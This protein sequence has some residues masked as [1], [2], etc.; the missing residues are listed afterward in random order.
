MFVALDGNF[1]LRRR[2]ASKL[3]IIKA[4]PK[5]FFMADA[6]QGKY[7]SSAVQS[8]GDSGCESE[9]TSSPT[10]YKLTSPERIC[11][12]RCAHGLIKISVY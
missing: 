9:F 5:K 10:L 6:L 1:Q 7:E 3:D 12:E 8:Q 2:K 4:E 11:E